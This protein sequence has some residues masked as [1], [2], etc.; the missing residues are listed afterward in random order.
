MV[1]RAVC[2]LKRIAENSTVE[3][4]VDSSSFWLLGVTSAVETAELT[5]I[6]VEITVL[7]DGSMSSGC[8]GDIVVDSI[9]VT[10]LVS[11]VVTVLSCD[12]VTECVKVEL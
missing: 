11:R 4:D 6:D 12:G 1:L 3:N 2:V 5:E 8:V 10:A 7:I 9:S